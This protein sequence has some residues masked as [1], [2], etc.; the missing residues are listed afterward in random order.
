M[1]FV[2]FNAYQLAFRIPGIFPSNASF[3]SMMRLMRNLRYTPLERPVSSHRRT[4]RVENFGVRLVFAICAFVVMRPPEPTQFF[5]PTFWNGIPNC[6]STNRLFSG[7]EFEKE[8]LMFIPCVNW[9]SAMLISGN[10]PCSFRPI[11]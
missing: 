7:S 3:R 10:T 6:S 4:V 9:T 11:E 2:P 1:C 8:K 5:S